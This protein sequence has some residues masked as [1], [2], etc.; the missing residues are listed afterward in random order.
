MTKASTKVVRKMNFK[1]FKNRFLVIGTIL[2]SIAYLIWRIFFTI[3]FGYGII[4]VTSGIILLIVEIIGM[5][6]AGIHFKNMSN[7]HYP[8]KPHIEDES[9]FPDVD[10]FIATYNEP[11]ELL[12]KTVNGCINMDYP[13]KSKVH[14]YICDDSNRP[15]MRNLAHDMK[16]NY[17]TRTEHKD[18]KAGNLNNALAHT[19]SPLVAT[20]DADM[21]PMHDFLMTCV[22]YFIGEVKYEEYR[23]IQYNF[24]NEEDDIDKSD[25]NCGKDIELK[26]IESKYT[27]AQ[28]GKKRNN[29][30]R[31][32][33]GGRRY[34]KAKRNDNGK[35]G[36]I[37]LPQ[38]FYNPDL[39]QYNLFSE[40]R[41]PNE[42]DYFYRDIQV[43]R[44]K[45]NSVIYGGSNTVISREALNEIGGFYT[46]VITEDFATGMLIQSKGYRCYAIDE[47]HASGLSPTDLKSLIKQ[48]ERW[49]RG[50]IQTGKKLNILFRKGLD[51]EQKLSYVS[52]ISY[53]Y[54]G[55]KRFVYILSPIIYAV[56]GVVVVKCTVL[57]VL[58]FWLPMYLFQDASLRLLSKNIRSVKWSN[59]YE[60]ILFPSLLPTVILE[61]IGISQNK[62]SVTRKGKAEEDKNY[63][64]KKT[65]PHIILAVLSLIGIFN[66][67][68]LIFD[69]GSPIYGIL[70]FWLILNFYNIIM[71]IFFMLGRK[72]NREHERFYI[73]TECTAY[74]ELPSGNMTK[75]DCMTQDIS[76][77]G[78]SIRMDFPQ[79][80][81]YDKTLW[82]VISTEKYRSCFEC[83][84]VH[85]EEYNH[86]WKYAFWIKNIDE[87]NYRQ[88]LNII[89]DREPTLPKIIKK[90]SGIFDDIGINISKRRN[91]GINF[92]RKLPRIILEKEFDTLEAGRISILNFNYEYALIKIN[93][94]NEHSESN[95]WQNM[96]FE[97]RY[98]EKL[99]VL[100]NDKL[101]FYCILGKDENY[102][103]LPEGRL[104]VIENYEDFINNNEFESMLRKWIREHNLKEE[105]ENKK[106][107]ENKK[108]L[109]PDDELDELSK[110]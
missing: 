88:L 47:I 37:Q 29:G 85:V 38:S 101:K 62:F 55:L 36:F 61:S 27:K 90:N 2:T 40:N 103:N 43:A 3:P 56:F 9:L 51:F 100:L 57:Q 24:I 48:R 32:K 77:S 25:E 22:P 110:L 19:S 109:I 108:R 17:I 67:V 33:K 76:E 4:A 87:K 45:S 72:I 74:F 50:C 92:N 91:K 52:A 7:I 1:I 11:V 83:R 39:F 26:N 97:G 65:V 30:Q 23:S 6:E 98:P 41:I 94:T 81:P 44:N 96:N 73:S 12:Y 95:K 35:I 64:I 66:C 107:R 46:K 16:V 104:Y 105:Y 8:K 14:I 58:V 79:Y 15:E 75:I 69:L 49:G 21:I 70:L 93:Y 59:I 106:L 71:S 63:Q 42:Q 80:I 28:M 5:I 78:M 54:S 31:Y 53:W 68:R 86:A 89:Y 20:F 84:V 60:T 34:K 13:D 18:A 82:A 102:Q 10:V 99:T